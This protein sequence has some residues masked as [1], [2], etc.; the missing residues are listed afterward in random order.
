MAGCGAV[1][2]AAGASGD[3]V[4][5]PVAPVATTPPPV[6]A[7]PPAT[8]VTPGFTAVSKAETDRITVP[9]GSTATV[10]FAT[11]DFLDASVPGYLNNG[12]Q[13]NF[14]R[15]FGDHHDGL[16]FFGLIRLDVQPP[17]DSRHL[18]G[19]GRPRA[20]LHVHQNPVFTQRHITA[21]HHQQLRQPLYPVGHLPDLRRELGGLLPPEALTPRCAPK[22]TIRRC[23]AM[24][25]VPVSTATTAEAASHPAWQAA[26]ISAAGTSQPTPPSAFPSAA[27]PTKARGLAWPSLVARWR[28]TPD[29]IDA[30]NPTTSSCQPRCRQRLT[31]T[32]ATALTCG[33][34]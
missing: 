5:S 25:S 9:A 34:M 29:A 11:G 28:S 15:R 30:A 2:L 21:R 13:K 26:L 32:D 1:S 22:K 14:A 20:R 3:E 4:L 17:C 33:A 12:S 18:D 6:I 31:P 24:A 10:I 16:H 7:P 23:C 19:T 27:A 8:G